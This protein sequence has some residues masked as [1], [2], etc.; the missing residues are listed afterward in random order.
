MCEIHT[1]SVGSLLPFKHYGYLCFN[2][3]PGLLFQ[4][5]RRIVVD[6]QVCQFHSLTHE[7]P[8]SHPIAGLKNYIIIVINHLE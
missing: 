3:G 6:I 8:E 7:G 5:E 2:F 4:P 1:Y